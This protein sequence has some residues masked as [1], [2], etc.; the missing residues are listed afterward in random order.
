M[1]PEKK[2][3]GVSGQTSRARAKRARAIVGWQAEI[4]DNEVV[5]AAFQGLA[6][7]V[8]GFGQDKFAAQA[9]V[10]EHF[11]NEQVVILVVFQVQHAHRAFEEVG[12]HN[13]NR[14]V[15]PYPG[16]GSLMM[17]QKNPICLMDSTN[18]WKSTGLTT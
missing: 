9:V 3:N 18:C 2:T 10:P 13:F 14:F 7:F 8:P 17:A 15:S 11:R 6:K 12:F 1:V 4:G 5:E 16:G